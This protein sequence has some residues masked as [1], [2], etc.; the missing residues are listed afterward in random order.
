M[1]LTVRSEFSKDLLSCHNHTAG[2]QALGHI[3]VQSAWVL[4]FLAGLVSSGVPRLGLRSGSRYG[5]SF[6]PTAQV[7]NAVSTW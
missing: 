5:H 4:S 6:C 7:H 2:E 1:D 3:Q